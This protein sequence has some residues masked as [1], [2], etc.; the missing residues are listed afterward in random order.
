MGGVIWVESTPNLGSVF[1]FKIPL[2]LQQTSSS[3][4]ALQ[5]SAEQLSP[6]LPNLSGI[7]VLL[8]EDN[9]IN[10]LIAEELLADV[11][12]IV[13]I[14]DNGSLACDKVFSGI[15]YDAILMDVQ[16][17]VMDGIEATRKIR[18]QGFSLPIIAM[19][20]HAMDEEK[21]RC[22]R[23]GMNDHVSK[24]MDPDSFYETLAQWTKKPR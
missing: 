11:G 14:A 9:T 21:Q 3:V 4:P 1:T 12:V 5:N 8:V 2:E 15:N 18:E 6:V 23:A 17:P 7:R 24:P 10:Q 16:M 19:T 22:L 20:A 13:D